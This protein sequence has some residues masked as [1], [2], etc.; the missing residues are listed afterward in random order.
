VLENSRSD[1]ALHEKPLTH[2][3]STAADTSAA[4]GA[5]C[6]P[7]TAMPW[8]E[9]DDALGRLWSFGWLVSVTS[10]SSQ[11]IHAPH[12]RVRLRGSAWSAPSVQVYEEKI[13]TAPARRVALSGDDQAFL[14]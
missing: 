8:G 9:I 6:A 7:A 12:S 10:P 13:R 2:Q 4:S 5:R 11:L 3:V 14:S 1:A